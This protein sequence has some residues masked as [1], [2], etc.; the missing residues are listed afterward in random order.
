MRKQ[1]IGLYTFARNSFRETNYTT[2]NFLLFK[3]LKSH[4]TES[5]ILLIHYQL[6][7][8]LL[9]FNFKFHLKNVN[10]FIFRILQHCVKQVQTTSLFTTMHFFKILMHY[11]LLHLPVFNV[12]TS[13]INT[14]IHTDTIRVRTK[15]SFKVSSVILLVLLFNQNIELKSFRTRL[16]FKVKYLKSVFEFECSS[17]PIFCFQ[18]PPLQLCFKYII[19]FI[20]LTSYNNSCSKPRCDQVSEREAK[21]QFQA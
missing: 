19:A 5:K 2:V 14:L 9:S 7:F 1:Y 13:R 10:T 17:Y 3:G 4:A 15:F 16:D 11:Q 6:V 8:A 12:Q 20:L 21:F 18:G